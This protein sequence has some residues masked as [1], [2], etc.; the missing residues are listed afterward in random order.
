MKTIAVIL[1]TMLICGM[2]AA[3]S[4]MD[5]HDNDTLKITIKEPYGEMKVLSAWQNETSGTW[6]VAYIDSREGNVRFYFANETGF[7]TIT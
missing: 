4:K 3:S 2:V 1:I 6:T 7:L 5:I